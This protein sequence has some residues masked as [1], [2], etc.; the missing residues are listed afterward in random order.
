MTVKLLAEQ[1]L[2]FLS[3]KGSATGSTASIHVNMPDCWKAHVTA[4]MTLPVFCSKDMPYLL[5]CPFY[6]NNTFHIKVYLLLG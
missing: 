1:H 6:V 5:V 4:Q 2:E 3:L